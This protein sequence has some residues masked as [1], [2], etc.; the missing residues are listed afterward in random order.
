MAYVVTIYIISDD[1]ETLMQYNPKQE[2]WLPPGG[3]SEDSEF[4]ID[5]G[6]R[7]TGEEVGRSISKS[8]VFL[9]YKTFDNPNLDYRTKLLPT[10]IFIA[11]QTL[12][13]GKIVENFI[14]LAKTNVKQIDNDEFRAKWTPFEEIDYLDT[15][16]N[17][18]MQ[19]N[20]IIK[21]L[22]KFGELPYEIEMF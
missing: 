4:H 8:L 21:N 18:K 5:T 3:F 10:P 13:N 14:Y 9:G 22:D 7:E 16:D 15:F 12:T 11:E 20:F 17:V 6:I 2:A 19:L 1:K